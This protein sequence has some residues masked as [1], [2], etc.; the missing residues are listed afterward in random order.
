MEL[1]E[2]VPEITWHLAAEV[3]RPRRVI[4]GR[5]RVAGRAGAAAPVIILHAVIITPGTVTPPAP[6]RYPITGI[7]GQPE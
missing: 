2:P 4:A 3:P 7:M 5:R 1:R 6:R